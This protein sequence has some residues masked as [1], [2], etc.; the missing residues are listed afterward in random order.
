[1]KPLRD[2]PPAPEFDQD[3]GGDAVL[4][5]IDILP[6]HRRAVNGLRARAHLHGILRDLRGA[7]AGGP[8]VPGPILR[9]LPRDTGSACMGAAQ[10][11]GI[12]DRFTQAVRRLARSNGCP[13]AG[14]MGLHG[15]RLRIL[16]HTVPDE[17]DAILRSLHTL[18]PLL[19]AGPVDQG[20]VAMTIP[21]FRAIAPDGAWRSSTWIVAR[22]VVPVRWAA[23]IP[24]LP[25]PVLH[26]PC[27]RSRW[28]SSR[29]LLRH[30][31]R[32]LPM[33]PFGRPRPAMGR[34]SK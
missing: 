26:R 27:W 17:P 33:G 12:I 24:P 6:D 2:P 34:R 28:R 1:L 25:F 3:A 13:C 9:I 14:C 18:A 5:A 20:W 7:L 31:T 21:G 4:I 22:T 30:L 23:I 29:Y 32:E 19:H 8:S 16:V 10:L 11:L 15:V